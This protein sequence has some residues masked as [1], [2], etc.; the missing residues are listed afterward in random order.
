[1]SEALKLCLSF[2]TLFYFYEFLLG[3]SHRFVYKDI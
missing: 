2:E 1:M 3:N